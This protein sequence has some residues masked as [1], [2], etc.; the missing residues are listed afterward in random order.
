MM[1]LLTLLT[2]LC[3]LLT[4]SS[5]STVRDKRSA[6]I[7]DA[8]TAASFSSPRLQVLFVPEMIDF[9]HLDSIVGVP[10][11]EQ[12]GEGLLGRDVREE[13]AGDELG[14]SS[15]CPEK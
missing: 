11:R 12:Q 8:T 1:K 3:A 2:T 13:E 5:E 4:E 6:T 10:D 9:I 15:R 14:Q 7:C